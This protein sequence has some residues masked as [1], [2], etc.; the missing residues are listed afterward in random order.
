MRRFTFVVAIILIPFGTAEGFADGPAAGDDPYWALVHEPAAIAELKLSASQQ[1]SFQK[2]IDDVDLRYFPLRNKS[3]EVA[4]E[5]AAK[6]TTEVQESL[7][8]LLDKSQQTRLN[9]ISL[10]SLGNRS[11]LQDDVLMRLGCTEKQRQQLK[12]IG[13]T[14]LTA[15]AALQKDASA[16]Q[17][18]KDLQQKFQK[19]QVAE[20]KKMLSILQ[21]KQVANLKTLLGTPFDRSKLGNARFKAPELVDTGEWINSSPLKLEQLRGKVVVIHFYAFGCINCIHNFPWYREWRER[22]D[23]TKVAIIGIH[24]PETAKERE[25]ENVRAK[26]AEEKFAFPVLIDG[27]NDNWNAW[28]NAMWPS[29]YVIDQQGYL[30]GFWAGELKWQGNDGEKAMRERIAALLVEQRP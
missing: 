11:L 13:E 28:G 24:T 4:L 27:K 19:L 30:R 23:E 26:A 22:F 15:V 14:T 29:V 2:L 7:K 9:E 3:Q 5:G 8:E 12:K 1:A 17:P 20:Q 18:A 10:Q 25:S 21:P 6:L 16:G